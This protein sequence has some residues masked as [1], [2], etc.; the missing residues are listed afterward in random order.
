MRRL[1]P[2]TLFLFFLWSGCKNDL[3]VLSDYKDGIVT[4]AVLDPI[5]TVHYVRISKV[6][7]GEGN[8]LVFAQQP[9]S[10]GFPIG[11]VD[12]KIQQWQNGQL[13]QTYQLYAD[14]SIPRDSGI[15]LNP[16]QV[17][18]RGVFPVLKD[19][20]IYKLVVIDLRK[21][22]SI[23]A[24]TTI[25]QDPVMVSPATTTVPL[26]LWDSTQIGFKFKTGTYGKRYNFKI[27]FHYTEQFLYDT[28]QTSEH[29]VD[30]EMGTT[31]ATTADGNE[32]LSYFVRRDRFLTFC[33]TQIPV[34]NYVRRI[35][36]KID[37]MF[38]AAAPELS[39]YIEVQ[40]ANSNSNTDIPPYSNITG[41]YGLF[42]SRTTTVIPNYTIDSDTKNALRLSTQTQALNFV[43]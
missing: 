24:E 5:D 4:Y 7:L 32:L 31:D 11:T 39:N 26:K 41:G 9:D 12:V 1:F 17:L 20:S 14:T 38:I 42:S 33:G 37:F 27:R 40:I 36:G 22:T 3:D 13:M 16:Y 28:T 30:W 15:F 43:R 19:G 6:F 29:Y 25:A 21:G 18:Y 34:K 23:T 35:S 8:A 10:I 2:F